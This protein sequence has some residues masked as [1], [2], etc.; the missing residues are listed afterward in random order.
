MSLNQSHNNTQTTTTTTTTRKNG[1]APRE[2]LQQPQNMRTDLLLQHPTTSVTV[3]PLFHSDCDCVVVM[4]V[5]PY[6]PDDDDTVS[7]SQHSIDRGSS[8]NALMVDTRQP[9]E[10]ATQDPTDAH[11]VSSFPP[12]PEPDFPKF[13]DETDDESLEFDPTQI[14][15]WVTMT[16]PSPD[17]PIQIPARF[18]SALPSVNPIPQP[19]LSRVKDETEDEP[20]EFDATLASLEDRMKNF[21]EGEDTL[22]DNDPFNCYYLA[23]GTSCLPPWLKLTVD[24]EKKN[25]YQFSAAEKRWVPVGEPPSLKTS[26]GS[27]KSKDVLDVF[28]AKTEEK[29]PSLLNGGKLEEEEMIDEEVG[30]E[31]AR[32]ME[33]MKDCEQPVLMNLLDDVVK[34]PG[35]RP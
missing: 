4:R 19:D 10:M 5:T 23:D 3:H 14:N 8:N 7:D 11:P 35:E 26:A 17:L 20:L 30:Q 28:A 33:W 29:S 24:V 16:R 34:N 27:P 18:Q 6:T 21:F 22:E 32:V 13:K 2:V 31:T 1:K 12:L 15:E 9:F 25:P